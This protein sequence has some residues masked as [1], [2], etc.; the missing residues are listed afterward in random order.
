MRRDIDHP[1]PGNG[2]IP[3]VMVPAPRAARVRTVA[4]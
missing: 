4:S 2:L 3:P 1:W